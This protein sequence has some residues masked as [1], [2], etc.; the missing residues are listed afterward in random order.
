MKNSAKTCKATISFLFGND[1]YNWNEEPVYWL[2][3]E[4]LSINI[5]KIEV[6][7]T[8]LPITTPEVINTPEPKPTMT[9]TPTVEPTFRPTV[10]PTL[11]PTLEPKP[12]LTVTETPT[13]APT[14]MAI[15]TIIP[16]STPAVVPTLA[17]KS[18]T[19]ES[20]TGEQ[21][22]AF[23]RNS[24]E[25]AVKKQETSITIPGSVKFKSL[26]CKKSK[27][28]ISWKKQKGASYYEVNCATDLKFKKLKKYIIRKKVRVTIGKIKR[29]KKY[30]LKIRA[31]FKKNGNTIHGKW[32]KVKCL[33]VR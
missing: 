25:T 13:V 10:S 11:E 33:K 1:S 29:K 26:K 8:S 24:V 21:E 6:A 17:P 19:M 3:A 7:P 28:L 27:I 15:P 4:Q 14:P 12:T 32:S 20:L 30:Y 22:K 5:N 2:N 23:A 18:Y 9:V 16:T 31:C